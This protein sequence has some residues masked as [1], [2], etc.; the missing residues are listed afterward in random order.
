MSQR[1][2]LPL[3]IPPGVSMNSLSHDELQSI[4]I[5][6]MR[7]EVNWGRK[8]P[9][10]KRVK[11]LLGGGSGSYVDEMLFLPGAK[12]LLTAQRHRQMEGRWSS[13]VV[14]WSLEDLENPHELAIIE[15]AGFY[16]SSA[17]ELTNGGQS[18][19]LVVGVNDGTE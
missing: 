15:A 19:T 3:D 14:L 13:H 16:R 10:L 11:P 9:L 7:L 6:A 5:K 2:G 12:W 17:I 8:K 18:A 4:A 1:L